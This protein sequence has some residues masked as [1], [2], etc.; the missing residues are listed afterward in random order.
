[1]RVQVVPI[2][3][4]AFEEVASVSE[5]IRSKVVLG[6]GASGVGMTSSA[7]LLLTSDRS[8]RVDPPRLLDLLTLMAGSVSRS[9]I[10]ATSSLF[11]RSTPL[12][13]STA[14]AT[15]SLGVSGHRVAL[16][17]VER[18]QDPASDVLAHAL[19][20]ALFGGLLTFGACV[21]ALEAD[22]PEFLVA[23]VFVGFLLAE[24]ED[25]RP[26][27]RF[28]GEGKSRRRIERDRRWRVDDE[29]DRRIKTGN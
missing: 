15:S 28:S 21:L 9:V 7:S 16:P 29:G 8:R 13:T 11:L 26:S 23:E 3:E 14:L 18:D 27:R 4:A 2:A 17:P 10:E 25:V 20:P 19:G 6:R 5:V 24:R 1:M 12:A 22:P